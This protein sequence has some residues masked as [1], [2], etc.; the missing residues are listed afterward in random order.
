MLAIFTSTASSINIICRVNNASLEFTFDGFECEIANELEIYEKNLRIESVEIYEDFNLAS[1]ESNSTEYYDEEMLERLVNETSNYDE[2]ENSTSVI[3]ENYSESTEISSKKFLKLRKT[4]SN[5]SDDDL[6]INFTSIVVYDNSINFIPTGLENFFPNLTLVAIVKSNLKEIRRHDL[7]S[8]P[9]LRALWLPYNDIEVIE[10]HLFD[11]TPHLRQLI[12]TE[13]RLR[14][15]NLD[16]FA[17]VTQLEHLD[18][19]ANPCINML[20]SS[21]DEVTE[22]LR[23]VKETCTLE[24]DCEKYFLISIVA[25]AIVCVMLA[26]CIIRRD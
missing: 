22:L 3:D 8:F 16:A 19:L 10:W 7:Q 18:L 23:N 15:I 26:L 20:A 1:D 12:L 21:S 5:S 17:L 11:L 2:S 25:V 14:H 24:C 4:S 9:N 13:N 6:D